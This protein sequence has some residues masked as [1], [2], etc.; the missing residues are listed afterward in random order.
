MVSASTSAIG[1]GN[2]LALDN[3]DQ[4][5][6]VLAKKLLRVAQPANARIRRQNDRCRHYRPEEGAA[7]HFVH[8]GNAGRAL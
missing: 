4:S 2:R 1:N 5:F 8:S 7:P 3:L 6:P